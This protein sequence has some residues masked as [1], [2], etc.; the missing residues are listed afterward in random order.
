MLCAVRHVVFAEKG[1]VL[2][3][4]SRQRLVNWGVTE[5]RSPSSA[6]KNGEGFAARKMPDAENDNSL[7]QS[8]AGKN[9]AGDMPGKHV[10]GV[11]HQ[12]SFH[13]LGVGVRPRLR[14]LPNPPS[15]FVRIG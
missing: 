11:R 7:R 9:G 4:R 2:F 10:A 1:T 5:R 3:E 13:G 15:Q 12:A 14:A 8:D 6:G